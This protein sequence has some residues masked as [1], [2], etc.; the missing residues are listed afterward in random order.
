MKYIIIISA[1]LLSG[2]TPEYSPTKYFIVTDLYPGKK[3]VSYF[4]EGLDKHWIK[5]RSIYFCGETGEYNIGD[6]LLIV[7]KNDINQTK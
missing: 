5:H 2:C 7:K 4:A 1:F 3:G 6:T